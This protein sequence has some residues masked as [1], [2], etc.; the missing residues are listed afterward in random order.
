MA[1]HTVS[2]I[3]YAVIALVLANLLYGMVKRRRSR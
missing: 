3:W 1:S 2:I